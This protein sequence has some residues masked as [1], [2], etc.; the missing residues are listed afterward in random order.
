MISREDVYKIAALWFVSRREE[1]ELRCLLSPRTNTRGVTRGCFETVSNDVSDL[2]RM[3]MRKDPVPAG[4][5]RWLPVVIATVTTY[6]LVKGFG[7]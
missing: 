4:G 3:L 7:W 6:A 2:A 1:M 5:Y